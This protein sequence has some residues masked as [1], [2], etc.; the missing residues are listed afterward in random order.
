MLAQLLERAG[1][2]AHCIPLGTTVEVMAQIAQYK[3]DV[4]CVSALPPFAIAHARALCAKL[5]A[6][7]PNLNIL[8]GLW[9]FAGDTAKASRRIGIAEAGRTFTMLSQIVQEVGV[10]SRLGTILAGQT[11]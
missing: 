10:S 5:H 8:V 2:Q 3:P 11:Q 7:S 1:H 6:Q 4:V 9:N